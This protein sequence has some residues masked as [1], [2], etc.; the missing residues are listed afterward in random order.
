MH[1]AVVYQSRVVAQYLFDERQ[2]RRVRRAQEAKGV[3]GGVGELGQ[4][5]VVAAGVAQFERRKANGAQL[6]DFVELLQ[7]AHRA[8]KAL[9]HRVVARVNL[10]RAQRAVITA[11][12][13]PGSTKGTLPS[14]RP[15]MRSTAMP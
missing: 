15:R 13:K 12:V 4:H 6:I 1:H 11:R 8:L 3:V 7:R 2:P 14:G 5:H 9:E 10:R